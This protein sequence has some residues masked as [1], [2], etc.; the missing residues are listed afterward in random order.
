MDSLR[1]GISAPGNIARGFAGDLQLV[2]DATIAAV[3]SRRLATAQS[4]AAEFGAAAAYGSYDEVA[5]DPSVDVV[6]VAN[7]HAFHEP[8]E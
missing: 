4:F 1:W 6:Y 7:P 5:N 8:V 2:D 3:G